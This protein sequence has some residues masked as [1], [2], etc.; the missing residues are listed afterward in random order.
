MARALRPEA[1]GRT[2]HITVRATWG[3]ELFLSDADRADF[4][5]LLE[6]IVRRYGWELLGWCLMGTHY[7]LIVR[8]PQPNLGRGMRDLNGA[9]A[10]RFNER[11]GRFGS[12]LAERYADRVIR[13]HEHLVKALRY[14]ALNPVQ[15][16]IVT[17]PEHWPWSSH[18]ALAGLARRPFFLAARA[19]LRSFRG[20]AADYRRFVE[21]CAGLVAGRVSGTSQRTASGGNATSTENGCS[22]HG[23]GSASTPSP[24]PTS[25]P[26]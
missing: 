21:S 12:V 13:S 19:A 8:T 11:H 16:R 15:A 20:R 14:V 22:F 9:Y 18:G 23:T 26:P 25:E 2:F 4:M 1:P 6:R 5:R 3:R 7:H 24:L 17:R 10:R